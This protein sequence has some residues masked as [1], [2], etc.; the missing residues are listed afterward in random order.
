[1]AK[2][3]KAEVFSFRFPCIKCSA[4]YSTNDP[5]PYYCENCVEEK[6]LIAEKIDKKFKTTSVNVT[7]DFQA[8]EATAQI[9]NDP[10][11]GRKVMF[12]RA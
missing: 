7:S 6:Q 8:F 5:E 10:K 11:T 3:Q 12:G 2:K 1:M 9:W 4:P